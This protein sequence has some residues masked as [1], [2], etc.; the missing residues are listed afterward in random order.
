MNLKIGKRIKNLRN[1]DDVTQEKLADAI[2]V[3]SQAISK[4]ENE[5][6]YPDI[7]YITPIANFFN[8]TIDE[9]F[10]HDKGENE[11]KIK[12][13]KSKQIVKKSCENIVFEE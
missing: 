8:V 6:G 13:C 7:E 1:R 2:G 12:K 11:N 4:W 10:G 5:I 9:L 3:T